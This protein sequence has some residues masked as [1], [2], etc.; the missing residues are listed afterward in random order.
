METRWSN[1]TEKEIKE[2]SQKEKNQNNTS[3]KHIDEAI[4][5]LKEKALL[6][7]MRNWEK[8]LI[9]FLLEFQ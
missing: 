7:Y 5:S 3:Y 2:K 9:E 6:L 8:C 4:L 1:K